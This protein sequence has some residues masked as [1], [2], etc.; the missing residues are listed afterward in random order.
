[1]AATFFDLA[2]AHFRFL[3]G[4]YGFRET[5]ANSALVRTPSEGLLEYTSAS[6]VVA[7]DSELGDASLW[8]YRLKDGKVHYLTPAAI[9]EYLHT[10]EAE[11]A[12]LLSPDPADSAGAAA[13]FRRTF[14]LDGPGWKSRGGSTLEELE[15]RLANYAGWLREHAPLCIAGDFSRWPAFYAYKVHRARADWLRRGDAEMVNAVVRGGDGKLTPV[16]RPAFQ[17]QLAH[18]EA[19]ERECES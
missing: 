2:R 12:P 15:R 1:M 18:I 10:T 7:V 16:K 17:D 5:F 9:H 13:I 14:L 3:E 4:E 19:L 11:K 8:F 6:T